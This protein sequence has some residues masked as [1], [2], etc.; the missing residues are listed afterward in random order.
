MGR[1]IAR[2]EFA[3]KTFPATASAALTA[4]L[5]D[6]NGIIIAMVVVT[7]DTQDGITY[8]VTVTNAAGATLLTFSGLAD[9]SAHRKVARSNKATQDADFNEQPVA[10]E[11]LT[12]TI[13]PSAAPDAGPVGS[14]IATVDVHLYLE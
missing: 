11:T 3:Q 5:P 10:D 8:T 2:L 14:K 12:V 13:T 9:N 7:T 4:T 6:V 1:K